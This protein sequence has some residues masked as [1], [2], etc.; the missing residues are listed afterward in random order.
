LP[1]EKS[2]STLSESF[3][4]FF[5]DKITSLHNKLISAMPTSIHETQPPPQ[6]TLLTDFQPLSPDEIS[7]LIMASPD[8]QCEL[9]P[10]PTA[11]L[12]KCLNSHLPV[13]TKIVNLSI[14]TGSFPDTFKHSIITPLLKKPSLDAEQ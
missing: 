7:K 9:D 6:P 2:P 11:L 3:A 4:T 5:S 1:T 14:S 8:K 13:I 12:K 10:N